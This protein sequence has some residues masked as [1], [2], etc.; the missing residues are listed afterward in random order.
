MRSGVK[1]L[2]WYRKTPYKNLWNDDKDVLLDAIVAYTTN[3]VG[4]IAVHAKRLL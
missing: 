4:V 1:Q 2:T 3:I